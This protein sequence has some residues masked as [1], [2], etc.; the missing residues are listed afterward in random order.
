MSTESSL[1]DIMIEIVAHGSTDLS[2]IQVAG[3]IIAADAVF[4]SRMAD[5]HGRTGYSTVDKMFERVGG[6]EATIERSRSAWTTFKEA[7]S[8]VGNL[9]V[10]P[11]QALRD[12]LL[13]VRRSLEALTPTDGP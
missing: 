3:E 13:E 9:S 5:A 8:K 4:N 7:I 1:R 11:H 6:Y 12:A 2:V 10:E